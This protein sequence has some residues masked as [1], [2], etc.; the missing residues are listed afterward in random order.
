MPLAHVRAIVTS[1]HPVPAYEGFQLPDEYME[2]IADAIQSGAM[3]M[4]FGHDITRPVIPQNVAAGVEPTDDGFR[5]VW[6]EF[7][8]DADLWAQFQSEVDAAGAPGGMSISVTS[9]IRKPRRQAVFHLAA[10]SGYFDDETIVTAARKLRLYGGVQPERL[11]QFSASSSAKVIIEFTA[12]MLGGIGLNILAAA[13]WDAAKH[14]VRP[15]QTIVFNLIRRNNG[16][17]LKIHIASDSG[18]V[19][20]A[21]FNRLPQILSTM[22]TGTALYDDESNSFRQIVASN[23]PLLPGHERA[24]SLV[25]SELQVESPGLAQP[26]SIDRQDD[27]HPPVQDGHDQLWRAPE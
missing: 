15:R 20:Q 13:L 26:P 3:P 7:D 8:V 22:Q 27:V 12:T 23:P 5:A 24:V 16:D 6:V 21:A 10:D 18:D 1:T 14:F 2:K 17:T 11:Y 9:P 25:D 19:M 4:H